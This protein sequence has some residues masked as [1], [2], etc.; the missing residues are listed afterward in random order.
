[1]IPEGLRPRAVDGT[2]IQGPANRTSDWRVHY[3]LDLTT[4]GCDWHELTTGRGAEGLERTPVRPGDVLIADRGYC[5]A[6]G[7]RAVAAG[8]AFVLVRMRWNHHKLVDENDEVRYYFTRLS[9]GTHTFY[10]R[11]RAATD[12]YFVHPAPWAEQMYHQ[13]VRGRGAGMRLE[14]NK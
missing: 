5:R 9:K 14:I 7:I 3:T 10:F 11:V 1:M 12:G 6:R 2:T 13:D 4:L 8:G